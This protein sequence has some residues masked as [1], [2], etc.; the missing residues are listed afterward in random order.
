M[1]FGAFRIHKTRG[2]NLLRIGVD[3]G[4]TNTDAVVVRGNKLIAATKTPTTDDIESGVIASIQEILTQ[5]SL[6]ATHV[7]CVMIGTTQFTNAFIE[8]NR[9]VPVGV[10]RLALPASTAVPPFSGWP[11]RL[12]DVVNGASEILGG[13]YEFDGR[14][15]SPI[16]EA[17]VRAT[18]KDFAFKGL[19]AVAI[20]SAFAPIN[21]EMENT[22]AKIV[23]EEMPD[24]IITLSSTFGRMGLIE[25]ENAAIMNAS[26][27]SLSNLVVHSF[28]RALKNLNINAPFYISQNDGTL[29]QASEVA[30]NPVMTF[31]SGPTNSIRGAAFLTGLDEAI[32]ADIGGTTTDVGVL[33]NGFPRESA[34]SADIGGVR[35]NFRMPDILSI[36]L[37]GGSLVARGDKGVA[38]GPE[39]V[40]HKIAEKAVVFG[41]DTLTATD[42]AVAGRDC[43][44]GDPG[45]VKSLDA[46]LVDGA[47]AQ[48]DS[49]LAE[50]IDRMKTSAATAPV[51]LVGGGAIIAP[52]KIAGAAEVSV[53]EHSEVANAVGA[54][55]AQVSGEIDTIFDYACQTREEVLMEAQQRAKQSA[56]EAGARYD[57]MNVVE[58]EELP[59]NYLP[60][61]RVR[62]RVKV[63]G[64]LALRELESVE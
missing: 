47:L 30:A 40:G 54:A 18:A 45:K 9:L 12:N 5:A 56:L 26:L 11:E 59:L 21:S 64:D 57:S 36:G 27:A 60:G 6:D 13:G 63:V 53:P 17:G 34:V 3:V 52:N 51:I 24:A 10:I 14:E 43:K 7:D 62:V 16:D 15:I 42:I 33:T 46:D 61:Q 58:I 4:G 39:S 2:A 37:G 29:M 20:S 31:A 41:G 25:R 50:S 28:A 23:R 38:V 8:A 55:I 35:T 1:S 44:I 32:V 49:L 22:A 19:K 48:I